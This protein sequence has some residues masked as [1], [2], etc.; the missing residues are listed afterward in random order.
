VNCPRGKLL[1]LSSQS[2]I[3]SNLQR[4]VSLIVIFLHNKTF[5]VLS[6]YEYF[7]ACKAVSRDDCDD[8]YDDEDVVVDDDDDDND[9]CSAVTKI[10]CLDD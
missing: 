6:T 8:D 4:A 1:K 9:G 2:V 7:S 5:L 3:E 10:D